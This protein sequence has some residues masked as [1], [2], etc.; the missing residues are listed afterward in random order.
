MLKVTNIC[1]INLQIQICALEAAANL[2]IKLRR[3]R[4]ALLKWAGE[5]ILGGEI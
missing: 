1:T 4:K 3:L 5:E 2:C